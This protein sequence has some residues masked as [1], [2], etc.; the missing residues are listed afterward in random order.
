M[1]SV[2]SGGTG[3]V[4][5]TD[6]PPIHIPGPEVDVKQKPCRV[7]ATLLAVYYGGDNVGSEWRYEISVNTAV[8]SSSLRIVHCRTWDYVGKPV[9]DEVLEGGCGLS[10]LVTIGVRARERDWCIFDDIGD[11]V[12]ITMLPCLEE[13]SGRQVVIL[14]PV[15]EYPSGLWLW[16]FRKHK[17]AAFLYFVFEVTAQ[18]VAQE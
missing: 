15:P 4:V 1:E 13:P 5:V 9:Y 16:P 8:W 12:G 11:G 7:T 3:S 17:K 10:E 14:V 18:C 2:L 6:G